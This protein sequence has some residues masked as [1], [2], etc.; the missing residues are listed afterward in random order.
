MLEEKRKKKKH[1]YENLNESVLDL[2]FGG[3]FID[4]FSIITVQCLMMG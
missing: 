1:S 3:L 4:I 2:S